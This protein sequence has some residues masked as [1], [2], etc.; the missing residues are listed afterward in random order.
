MPKKLLIILVILTV[1]GVGG[2]FGWRIYQ[3]Q[4][5]QKA[6]AEYAASSDKVA[7]DFLKDLVSQNVDH[8][9]DN[10]FS[11]TLKSGYSKAYFKDKFFPLFKDYKAQPVRHSKEPVTAASSAVPNTY[12]PRFNQQPTRYQYDFTLHDLTYRVTFVIYKLSNQWKINEL[13]GAYL[14]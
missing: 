4:Q 5:A 12:D 13:T 7:D 8:A 1:L 9:Y 3:T 2:F 14:P 6:A 11:P 10:L